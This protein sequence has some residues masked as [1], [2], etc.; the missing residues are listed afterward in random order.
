VPEISRFLGIVIGM[1]YKDH[2]PPHFHATYGDHEIA[3]S[4]R[5]GEVLWGT[6]PKRALA[7]VMEWREAHVAE[8][9]QDWEQ[10][11]AKQPLL[12]VEPL[13]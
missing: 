8:L 5:D 2:N 12:P 11:R 6:F 4:I 9:E 7:H 13:E 3:V 10:A 1:F